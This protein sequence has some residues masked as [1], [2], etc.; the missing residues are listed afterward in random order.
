VARGGV[1]DGGQ[2][3]AKLCMNF[4]AHALVAA[5]HSS[6]PR[7]VLG[8]MLPDLASMA[9]VRIERASDGELARGIALHHQTDAAFHAAP[10]FTSLCSDAIESL[11]S[12]GVERGTARAVGHVGVELLLDGALS[13]DADALQ[14]YR[15]ALEFAQRSDLAALLHTSQPDGADR[16]RN[17]LSRL[18]VAPLPAAYRE[19]RFVAQRLRAILAP[20]PRLAMRPGDLAHV[21]RWAEAVQPRVIADRTGLLDDVRRR[22]SIV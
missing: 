18:A 12:A 1:A 20:R 6:E 16:L 2:H 15:A 13:R 7:Y 21:E 9:S 11:S 14:C 19:P 8:A 3:R 10:H 4:F 22:L 5:W 17:G